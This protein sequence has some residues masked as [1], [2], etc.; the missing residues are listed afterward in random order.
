VPGVVS[1][2]LAGE[3]HSPV[4]AGAPLA[5]ERPARVTADVVVRY[6]GVR[7]LDAIN[8]SM[9]VGR[10]VSGT[11]VGATPHRR[12]LPPESL[13]THR[14]ARVGIIGRSPEGCELSVQLVDAG[15]SLAPLTDPGVC[16][17]PASDDVATWWV[18][19]EQD[20]PSAAPPAISV[21]ATS[22]RFFWVSESEPLARIAI[23]DADPGGRP[24]RIGASEL[25]RLAGEVYEARGASLATAPFAAPAAAF[26]SALFV[27]I[28]LGDLTLRYAR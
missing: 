23:H 13:R 8:D 11:I 27:T 9:P 6:G 18:D 19:L 1:V 5:A 17:V 21:R 2:T 14:V 15:P 26:E 3:P 25:V 7:L 24:V 10:A 4:F 16:T 22:G 12:A 20:E 28:E